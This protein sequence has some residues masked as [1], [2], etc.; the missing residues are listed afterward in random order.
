MSAD[1]SNGWGEWKRRVLFQLEEQ[2]KEFSVLNKNLKELEIKLTKMDVQLQIKS[3]IWG[4]L[5]GVIPI[6]IYLLMKA[7]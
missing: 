2:A 3:G 5:A 7:A 4:A 1:N 6:L